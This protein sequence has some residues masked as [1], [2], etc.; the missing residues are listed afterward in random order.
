MLLGQASSRPVTYGLVEPLL[1]LMR[2]YWR[3]TAVVAPL[4]AA[5][6]TTA[7]ESETTSIGRFGA[8]TGILG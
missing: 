7:Q 4:I 3:P 8:R 2:Q 5:P 1:N 6:T